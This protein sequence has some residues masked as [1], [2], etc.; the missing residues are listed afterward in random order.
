MSDFDQNE[1]VEK[2]D[3]LLAQQVILMQRIEKLESK[4]ENRYKSQSI[5]L[6]LRELKREAAKILHQISW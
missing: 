4:V 3:I 5:A 1:I 2:L 6:S